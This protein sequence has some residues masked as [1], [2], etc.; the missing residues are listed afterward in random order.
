MAGLY[1]GYKNLSDYWRKDP[2]AK[3][4]TEIKEARMK[5]YTDDSAWNMVMNRNSKLK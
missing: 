1:K 3:K 5:Y 2:N 4:I